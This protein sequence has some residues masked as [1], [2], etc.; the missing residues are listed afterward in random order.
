MS[1]RASSAAPHSER[2]LAQHHAVH[3]AGL[4]ERRRQSRRRARIASLIL[5]LLLLGAT[6]YGLW[7]KQVRVS[8]VVIYGAD[9][10]LA[11]VATEA[12]RGAYLGIIPRDSTFFYPGDR[13]RAALKATDADIAAVS[14]F[15]TGL[16]GLSI[17]IDY[18]VP[19]ARWCGTSPE[20]IDTTR[21]DLGNSDLRSNLIVS[22]TTPQD[23]K[24]F[25]ANGFVY[26][27]S[28]DATTVNP[29]I[30]F[31][32]IVGTVLQNA[33]AFPSAFS[34]ARQLATLGSPVVSVTF[35]D[36]EVDDVLASGT[37]VTYLLGDEQNAFTALASARANMNF[38][39]G[40][41]EYV[42]LRFAGKVYLKKK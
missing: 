34:F 14:L 32:P 3:G 40:S 2:R 10:S 31:D 35:R 20:P 9:Q 24:F 41:L 5:L 4:A 36:A 1:G 42:D 37:R 12:M 38:A 29:F 22:S 17:K 26:A 30:V 18:R 19:I 23:C 28:T 33:N 25:D 39:D 21:F 15:R 11:E 8:H 16:D 6:S 7:Q 27:T 13:I